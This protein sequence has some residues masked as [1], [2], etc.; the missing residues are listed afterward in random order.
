[1]ERERFVSLEQTRTLDKDFPSLHTCFCNSRHPLTHRMPVLRHGAPHS[2]VSAQGTP[3]TADE[4]QQRAPARGVHWSYHPEA[5]GLIEKW[6]GLLKGSDSTSEV[7]IPCRAGEGPPGSH[8]CSEYVMMF[9]P[10]P[11][12][13]DPGIKGER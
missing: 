4:T 7:T 12:I 2:V 5:A 8:I 11:G 9:L 3:L 6:N 1:M 13:T 10:D